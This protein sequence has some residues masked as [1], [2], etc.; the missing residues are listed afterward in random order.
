MTERASPLTA[1]QGLCLADAFGRERA[2]PAEAAQ[3]LLSKTHKAYRCLLCKML[4][5]CDQNV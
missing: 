3:G 5:N 4:L 2:D 1:A